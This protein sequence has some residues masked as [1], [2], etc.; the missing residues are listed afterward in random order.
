MANNYLPATEIVPELLG[1]DFKVYNNQYLATARICKLFPAYNSKEDAQ[2]YYH[3]HAFREFCEFCEN[4]ANMAPQL[5]EEGDTLYFINQIRFG[6]EL[7]D[8]EPLDF[9]CPFNLQQ[10]GNLY[11]MNAVT[12]IIMKRGVNKHQKKIYASSYWAL[13]KFRNRIKDLYS[14]DIEVIGHQVNKGITAK[15][16]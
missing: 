10:I 14:K 16:T 8:L 3:I 7:D 5:E 12:G 13:I 4:Q 6:A 2:W 15:K 9:D 1:S 11:M